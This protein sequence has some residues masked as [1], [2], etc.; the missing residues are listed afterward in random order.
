DPEAMPARQVVEMATRRGAD[1]LGMGDRIGSL[2]VGKLADVI[3]V[4][5]DSA[6]Q[7][8]LFDPLSHLV[9]VTRGTDVRNTVV[10]GRVL[11][12]N[13][14]VLSLNRESVLRDARAMADRVRDAVRRTQ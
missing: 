7:T 2:E 6:R 9:Y 14:R 10:H 1:A 11:M 4:S 8:P 12:R 5:V 3:T 13:G